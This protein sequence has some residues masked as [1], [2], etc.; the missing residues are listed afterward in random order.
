M[1]FLPH[2]PGLLWQNVTHF[3]DE[4]RVGGAEKNRVGSM[5]FPSG[6]PW[7]SHQGFPSGHSALRHSAS[8]SEFLQCCCGGRSVGRVAGLAH[9]KLSG[10]V[11]RDVMQLLEQNHVK[12]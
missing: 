3:H 10:S 9:D 2:Q 11:P 8:S 5:G 4:R 7:A 1:E 12:W 6:L